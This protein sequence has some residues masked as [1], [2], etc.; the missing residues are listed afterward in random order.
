MKFD[1]LV[2]V[3]GTIRPILISLVEKWNNLLVGS[4]RFL[5]LLHR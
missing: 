5:H 4:S 2:L 3:I 1:M